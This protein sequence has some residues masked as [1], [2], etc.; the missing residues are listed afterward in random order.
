MTSC[1]TGNRYQYIN[2]AFAKIRNFC[3]ILRTGQLYETK[4]ML[5]TNQ[6]LFLNTVCEVETDLSPEALL[7]QCKQIEKEL[8]RKERE[9]YVRLPRISDCLH[10]DPP[11]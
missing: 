7:L 6:P 11:F 1:S 4:P 3:K 8:D 9:R 5:V 10:A 2:Q